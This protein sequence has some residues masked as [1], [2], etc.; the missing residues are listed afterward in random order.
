MESKYNKYLRWTKSTITKLLFHG[1]IIT[2][3][4]FFSLKWLIYD[5]MSLSYFA[6]IEKSTDFEMS[7][8]YNA[9][10]V[11]RIPERL[12]DQI[13]LIDIEECQSRA[14][15]AEVVDIVNST[16]PKA[17]GL[18]VMFISHMD[19]KVDSIL[20]SSI[21]KCENIVIPCIL[22]DNSGIDETIF[23][24]KVSYFFKDSLPHATEGFVN[25]KGRGGQSMIREFAPILFY[26]N[27]NNIDTI[28]SFSAEVA[29]LSDPEKFEK[30]FEIDGE[31]SELINY[32]RLRFQSFPAKDIAENK[33]SLNNKIVLIGSMKS[34]WHNTP[35]NTHLPGLKIHAYTIST[36]INHKYIKEVDNLWTKCLMFVLCYF[37]SVICYYILTK[38]QGGPG[39]C[40]RA[41]QFLLLYG[42]LVLG[43][44]CFVKWNINIYFS[45][46]L[47]FIGFTSIIADIYCGILY[48]S[49]ILFKKVK[50]KLS[51]S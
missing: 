30:M 16:N 1:A 37:F 31:Y 41:I 18:D 26:Q 36:I 42:C 29:R 49:R 33:V 2:F 45:K 19:N 13:V 10:A 27:N 32:E 12:N 24:T 35:I 28:Y 3:L 21:S 34:D 6:P 43:Y 14:E 39:F 51:K 11:H 22:Q 47:L 46:T 25:L 20:I 48:W 17:I 7:D 15:I 9:I 5:P 4:I 40:I 23:S 50:T 8:L 38:V 44:Y